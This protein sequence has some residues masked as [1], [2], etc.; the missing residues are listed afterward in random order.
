[1]KLTDIVGRDVVR[2][3][4]EHLDTGDLI[5]LGLAT[6]VWQRFEQEVVRGLALEL[7]GSAVDRE[8]VTARAT[9]FRRR[10]RLLSAAEFTA[11]LR[12]RGLTLDELSGVLGHAL[13][14]D[15]HPHRDDG[16]PVSSERLGA[17]LYAEA[18]C[19]GVLDELAAAGVERL[20]AAHRLG[21]SPDPD[22]EN[23]DRV[24]ALVELA[25][26]HAA[27]GL[28]QAGEHA[29]RRRAERIV[30]LEQALARTREELAAD[31]RS[32][33]RRLRDHAIDWMRLRGNELV[34]AFPGA[35]RESRL[36]LT[37][38]R[39]S[40]DEV[41]ARA[42]TEV[43]QCSFY[44]EQVPPAIR[45]RLAS[46]RPGETAEPWEEEGA[47]HVFELGDKAAPSLEDGVLR[48]RILDE[49]VADTLKR[50]AA[51]RAELTDAV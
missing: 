1:V 20:A 42:R 23:P 11:W 33:Q 5:M 15:S 40:L 16:P 49:L 10:R 26:A 36:L 32:L 37:E 31:Q 41:A 17:V 25:L 13:L 51:G 21:A 4:D 6:G 8:Q 34:L 3:E 28:P 12:A 29:L 24:D 35:A 30:A 43:R 18:V 14:R 46:L 7:A 19:G 45:A 47:W 2:L 44:L 22:D 48:D 50:H 39:L 9:A 27:T 38:D